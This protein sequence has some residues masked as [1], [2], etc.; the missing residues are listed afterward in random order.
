MR[1]LLTFASI[2]LAV[3]LAHG[4]KPG[5]IVARTLL[6]SRFAPFYHGV[7]SG[8]PMPDRV[9]IWTRVTTQDLGPIQI[10]W[11]MATDT[12]M[13]N[14]V[15][16]G[17][18]TTSDT[19]DHTL[20][21]DVTGLNPGTWYYYRFEYQGRYSLT[22]RTYT[23]PA[24]AV[25][26]LRFGVVSCSNYEAGYFN[27]YG[28][29]AQRNDLF[30]IFHLGDYIYEGGGDG[31]GD[32]DHDPDHEIVDL[33]DYRIRHSQHKLDED[34]RSLHQM[35]PFVSVWDDHESANDSYKDGAENHSTGSEGPWADRKSAAIQAYKEWMPLRDPD[36]GNRERIWR[37]LH[38]G[39]LM[40]LIML[41]TR[42]YARDEQVS[43]SG[44]DDISRSLIGPEQ[45]GWLSQ[46]L[47]SSSAQWKVLG[48][49]VM[50]APLE[51]PFIGPVNT[52]Q[53]DGYRAERQRLYDSI[54][55][56]QIENVVVLTGDIHSAWA[57]DLPT[58]SYIPSTGAGSVGVEFV[59]TSITSTN[60]VVNVPIGIINSANP[61][62]KYVNLSD[63]G[64][65]V[66]DL[67]QARAQND[68]WYVTNV[69]NPNQYGDTWEESW[70]CA[71]T[72]A[73]LQQAADTSRAPIGANAIQP[74]KFP[75]NL[76]IAV[77]DPT[78]TDGLVALL[79][80][81]PNPFHTDFMLKYYLHANA[82]VSIRLLDLQG[83]VI[84]EQDLGKQ[85]TGLHI[86]EFS[87]PQLANGMYIAELNVNGR[88]ATQR[89]IKY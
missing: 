27:A 8:D 37:T 68:Y 49:Q 52:D 47:Q 41:D 51:V 6:D 10:N 38:Y 46:E 21:I 57:N 61:H 19:I 75:P 58:G 16:S 29:L 62:I 4:Q 31:A 24:G 42:L 40:D 3:S 5:D 73:H 76:A 85:S 44:I 60:S 22:G 26:S 23:A 77:D 30:G 48:Q 81:Y 9:V 80:G 32:R 20:K 72:T 89:M 53:W 84:E 2:L 13:T 39:N 28:A 74:P 87:Q 35:Y 78:T 88:T 69:A 64:Y 7:A 67:N 70:Y 59:C 14:V 63:H 66:L 12:G 56:R 71:D 1:L 25:D 54:L 50:M 82:R 18:A 83:R 55:T 36:P 65:S 43:G 45:L 11:A 79:G 86:V 34:L 15:Q 17:V 33:T